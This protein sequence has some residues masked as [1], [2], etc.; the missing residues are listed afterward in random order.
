MRV[1]VTG[2]RGYV[3]SVLVPMLLDHGHDVVGMDVDLYRRCS[4]GTDPRRVPEL[5]RD[6]RDAQAG[7]FDGID[8]VLHLAALSND[9]LGNLNPQITYDINHLATVHLARQA[10]EAGVQRFVFSSSCSNYGSK[11]TGVADESAPLEPV[12]PYAES[13]VLSERDLAALGT[14]DFSPTFLR[15]ATAYGL[16]PRHR[17]DL[18]VNNL[19]AWGF[20]TGKILLKSDGTPWRPIIHVED[21][22]R[23]FL[24][25]LETPRES[26]HNEAFNVAPPGENYRIRDLAEIVQEQLR[27][28]HIEFAADA[29]P[30]KRNYRVDS[31]KIFAKVPAFEPRWTA[32][33]GVRQLVDA[34]RRFGLTLEEFEGPRYNRIDHVRLLQREGVLDAELRWQVP[35]GTPEP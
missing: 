1:L 15:F 25:V 2:H 27:D 19:T 29:A 30:D 20:T 24:A 8:A 33:D 4:Y 26:I 6:V 12:T 34:Y 35:S 17:F 14:D 3:G 5:E 13:K 10:R 21:M 22:A 11:G 9:P 28:C 16:S 7:D 31:S 23:A 18:V 32:R